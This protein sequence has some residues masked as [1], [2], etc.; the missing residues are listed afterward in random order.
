[1]PI[2]VFWCPIGVINDHINCAFYISTLFCFTFK[3]IYLKLIFQIL[4]QDHSGTSVDIR[5]CG[6]LLAMEFF[7]WFARKIFGGHCFLCWKLSCPLFHNFWGECCKLLK[8]SDANS[9][10]IKIKT[11]FKYEGN[12]FIV[13][14]SKVQEIMLKIHSGIH[15][16]KFDLNEERVHSSFYH[17]W[18]IKG[19][20]RGWGKN[21][22]N[23]LKFLWF[24]NHL[25]NIIETII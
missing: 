14:Y 21:K 15:Y 3:I 6:L 23:F 11:F 9:K 7:L 5:L 19:S 1:M 8:E 22:S 4:Y 10:I 12:Q 13:D 25:F 16:M 18:A 24:K 2:I 17:K 20:R